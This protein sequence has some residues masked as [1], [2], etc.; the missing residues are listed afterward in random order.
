M[1]FDYI[2]TYKIAIPFRHRKRVHRSL[3]NDSS[4]LSKEIRSAADSKLS[5]AISDSRRNFEN[6]VASECKDNP[7][8][9]WSHVR[10]SFASKP[11]VTTV[12]NAN[13]LL[14]DCDI[15]TAEAFNHFFVTL[16]NPEPE[17]L[18]KLSSLN[19]QTPFQLS[20]FKLS[21]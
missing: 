15:D 4:H 11:K 8:R 20:T 17:H 10:A 5:I 19:N 14:T 16:F 3:R 18:D 2:S 6:K 12:Y 1:Q 9:F 13:G 21:F 7:K